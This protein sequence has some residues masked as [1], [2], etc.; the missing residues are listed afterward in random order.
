MRTQTACHCA[1]R[2][3]YPCGAKRKGTGLPYARYV[4]SLLFF[5]LAGNG[6][7]FFG[8]SAK[9][10]LCLHAEPDRSGCLDGQEA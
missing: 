7:D 5:I 1:V 9:K 8:N 2:M 6:I 10:K 3:V 4:I